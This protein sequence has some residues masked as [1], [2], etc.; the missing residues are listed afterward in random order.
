M[1]RDSAYKPAL[2]GRIV[3]FGLYHD[4]YDRGRGGGAIVTACSP[5]SRDISIDIMPGFQDDSKE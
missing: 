4:K 3:G 2:P 1:E 5:R